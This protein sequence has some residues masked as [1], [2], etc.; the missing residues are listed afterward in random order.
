MHPPPIDGLTPHLR[1]STKQPAP[2]T[3]SPSNETGPPAEARRSRGRAG[4]LATSLR[5]LA[6]WITAAGRLPAGTAWCRSRRGR[7]P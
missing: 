1:T 5:C 7:K 2:G 6:K 4:A 3:P